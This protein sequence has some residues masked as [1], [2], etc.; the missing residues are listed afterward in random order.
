MRWWK[1]NILAFAADVAQN[2]DIMARAEQ[3]GNCMFRVLVVDDDPIVP[4]LI[5]RVLGPR[6]CEVIGVEDGLEALNLLTQDPHFDLV[7]SDL[8]MPIMSGIRFL[9]EM[10]ALHP[11]TPVIM[12]SVHTGREQ[13]AEGIQKGIVDFLPK[14]FT[15]HQLVDTVHRAL[16]VK[17]V[18]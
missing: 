10:A 8:R 16:S 5:S 18:P 4:V 13:I 6:D 14:P 11:G 15:P 1:S 9:E 12:S 17:T 7:I 2:A 3:E